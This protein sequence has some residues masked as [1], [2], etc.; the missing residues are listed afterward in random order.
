VVYLEVWRLAPLCLMW[1]IW[2]EWNARNFE[3][4]ETLV[5]ELKN[6]FFQ[7]SLHWDSRHSIVW[8]FH[9][10][11]GYIGWEDTCIGS[12]LECALLN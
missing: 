2:R 12:G 5:L 11:R 6:I 1:C 9:Y 7:I 3:D 8:H 4:Q 10:Y